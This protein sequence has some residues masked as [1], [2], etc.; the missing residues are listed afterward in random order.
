LY[1]ELFFIGWNEKAL[2]HPA[3]F[4]RTKRAT[5]EAPFR[6]FRKFSSDAN[7]SVQLDKL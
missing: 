2:Q 6:N 5:E 4:S 3:L 7:C 1:S